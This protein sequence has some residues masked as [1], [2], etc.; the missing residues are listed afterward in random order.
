[1]TA[2]KRTIALVVTAVLALGAAAT[3]WAQEAGLAGL[4]QGQTITVEQAVPV[5]VTLALP[6]EDGTVVTAT[7]PL[8][9]GLS[10]QVTIEG[11]NVVSV[12]AAGPA[13]AA[14]VA[15]SVEDAA[16]P[17]A[18]EGDAAAAG[19]LVD[20]AGM[21]YAVETDKPVS[22]TQVRAKESM[23]GSMTQLVGELRNDGDEALEYVLLT[24][25]FYDADGA[26]L[27]IGAGAATQQTLGPGESSGFQAMASV[28][29]AEL[30]SYTI[31]V[32]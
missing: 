8:T 22:I 30:G 29:F 7:A 6:L 21:P 5:A 18:A 11:L 13:S 14:A 25:K 15:T 16:A 32:K 10:L 1:M 4:V 24:V 17:A 31:E 19:E 28:P 2:H 26:L 12:T 20:L 23:G 27:D 3:A 9:I